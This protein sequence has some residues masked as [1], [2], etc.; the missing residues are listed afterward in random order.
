MNFLKHILTVCLGN[1]V[2]YD[3]DPINATFTAGSTSTVI[4]VSVTVDKIVERLETFDLNL[5]I[6]FSLKDKIIVGKINTAV[7]SI[8]DNNSKKFL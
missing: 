3:S 4:N 8:I 6:P 5:T 7:A 2:D 1:G